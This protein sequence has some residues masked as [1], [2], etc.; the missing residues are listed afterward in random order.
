[1]KQNLYSHG[2]LKVLFIPAFFFCNHW[3][4]SVI[5]SK[6][7]T[8]TKCPSPGKWINQLWFIHTKKNKE[9]SADT[10]DNMGDPHMRQPKWKK[11]FS[12]ATYGMTIFLVW[13]RRKGRNYRHPEKVQACGSL[14]GLAT[15]RG[16]GGNH[17]GP[18]AVPHA[19]CA[20]CKH[21]FHVCAK[22]NQTV[23][24]KSGF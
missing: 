19:V 21:L 24:Q 18:G 12:K 16:G 7:W 20:G 22:I 14:T 17:T 15:G 5:S 1:M 3:L 8:P 13:H 4:T 2:N 23:Y 9:R 11:P 10:P 6:H